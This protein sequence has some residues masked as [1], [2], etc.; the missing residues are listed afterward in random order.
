MTDCSECTLHTYQQITRE[1][2]HAPLSV[3][4]TK[5]LCPNPVPLN[6]NTYILRKFFLEREVKKDLRDVY[7][8]ADKIKCAV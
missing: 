4:Y 7:L 1:L 5:R 3:N 6:A 8:C 2:N